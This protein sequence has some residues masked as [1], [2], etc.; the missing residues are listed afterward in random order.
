MSRAVE[1]IS[2]SV[3]VSPPSSVFR[4]W[5]LPSNCSTETYPTRAVGNEIFQ[6]HELGQ[7]PVWRA[8]QVLPPSVVR[9]ILAT[10]TPP[11]ST[12]PTTIPVSGSVNRQ[13][14]SRDADAERSKH[15]QVC[16]PS[17]VLMNRGQPL[18]RPHP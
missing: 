4:Q 17:V 7:R 16:P 12:A 15:D 11:S 8:L 2:T 6:H 14:M 1:A 18:N 5:V 9:R 3:Q 13:S 10:G